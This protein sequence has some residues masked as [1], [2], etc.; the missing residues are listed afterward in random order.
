MAETGPGNF[1][2]SEPRTRYASELANE[3]TSF[4]LSPI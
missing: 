1:A 3:A 4:G 2:T